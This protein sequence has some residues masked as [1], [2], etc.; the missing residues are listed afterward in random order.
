MSDL[1]KQFIKLSIP[2]ILANLV[3][4][5]ASIVD[6]SVLGQTKLLLPVAAISLGSL[7]F[8]YIFIGLNFF[9]MGT[10]ALTVK[11]FG[12]GNH[13]KVLDVL[14]Q[15]VIMS[16]LMGVLVVSISPIVN[17]VA[18]KVLNSNNEVAPLVS[19]YFYY[20]VIGAPAVLGLMSF[21]GWY[22]GRKRAGKCL[23]ITSMQNGLNIALTMWFVLKLNWGV[24]GA[25]LATAYASWATFILMLILG[26]KWY[27]IFKWSSLKSVLH[28]EKIRE[29]L[30][31]NGNLFI[32]TI[33][34]IST[35]SIFTNLSAL[36]GEVA[37]VVNSLL[38]RLLSIYSYFIDGYA[39]SL[40]AM[41]G[42][43]YHSNQKQ[44]MHD[45]F[46]Y[47]IMI[48]AITFLIF[49]GVFYIGWDQIINLL[50]KSSEVLAY[51]QDYKWY[52]MVTMFL[53]MMA[54]LLDGLFV[55]IGNAKALKNNIVVAFI[56]SGVGFVIYKVTPLNTILWLSLWVFMFIRSAY[57]FTL[58]IKKYSK[59]I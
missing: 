18:L 54:Y 8:D 2:N 58:Y 38:L 24:K 44:K 25:A 36:L 35:F 27:H 34:L 41:G 47:S 43:Y 57:L 56:L 30:H 33:C 13:D 40:E 26:K 49:S 48:S 20:R 52:L 59:E 23:F 1:K 21:N 28:R 29:F 50:N 6:V 3:I 5:I 4:P 55:G 17:W 53:A 12:S 11:E 16:L 9:R 19:E 31:L 14:K 7:I 42:E 39:F 51:S 46:L 45:I 10:T 15:S 37:L 32:R 22:L